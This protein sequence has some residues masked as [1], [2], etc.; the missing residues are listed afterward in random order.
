MIL[1]PIVEKYSYFTSTELRI[2]E[3]ILN[4][5]Q[6]FLNKTAS[7]LADITDTSPAAI[8]RFAKK[9]G[10]EGYS[11]MKIG[12][13]KY[14]NNNTPYYEKDLL[15]NADDTYE[16]CGSKLF[17]QITDVCKA[18]SSTIDYAN[19][20][21][22]VHRI[23][24]ADTIYLFGVG[25]SGTAAMDLQQKLLKLYKKVFYM[26]DSQI[27]LLST[28]TI[29]SKDVVIAYSYTGNTKIIEASVKAAK[30]QGAFAIAITGNTDSPI[31]KA[32]D[33]CILTPSVER[34]R[35]AGAVSSRYAQQ[36]ISDL[37]YL[38]L[39]SDH[40]AEAIKINDQVTELISNIN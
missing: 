7:Q 38:C 4:N 12:L 9:I 40:Y 29:S 15:V 10:F 35:N 19:L 23:D 1:V 18:I 16:L 34:K 27:N 32:A 20:A 6:Q 14:Y 31:G 2:A 33:T 28:I 25:S 3:Y 21:N 37:L 13:A 22:I 17:A 8:V 36:Y 26:Q 39:L 30:D 24:N 5:P 11:D